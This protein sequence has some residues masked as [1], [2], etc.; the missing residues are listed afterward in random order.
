MMCAS[1]HA[2]TVACL[3]T[4]RKNSEVGR[5]SLVHE[6][7]DF[8]QAEVANSLRGS[9]LERTFSQQGSATTPG[10]AALPNSPSK[11]GIPH[12]VSLTGNNT[13]GSILSRNVSQTGG[14]Y[15]ASN[16][17]VGG[18]LTLAEKYGAKY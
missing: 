8:E 10:S 12:S 7:Y 1:M 11:T 17:T 15:T 14:A 6:N 5:Y 4:I 3:Y 18:G 13:S 16:A 9:L 2:V